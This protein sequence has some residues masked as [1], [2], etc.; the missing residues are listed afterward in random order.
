MRIAWAN[1]NG[2][3]AVGLY[4]PLISCE[5]RGEYVVLPRLSIKGGTFPIDT[6][7]R[8]DGL[9]GHA[10]HVDACAGWDGNAIEG[11]EG[12]HRGS[13]REPLSQGTL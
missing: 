6:S 10:V 2:G 12:G 3:R 7:E 8:V 13:Q 4:S 1:G 9:Y 5:L 11:W